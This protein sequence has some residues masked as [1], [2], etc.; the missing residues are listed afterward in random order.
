MIKIRLQSIDGKVGDPIYNEAKMEE[1]VN[2]AIKDNIDL[3]VEYSD[4]VELIW[5]G[6][7]IATFGCNC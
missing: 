3:I 4:K 2:Q 6:K 7:V 5:D 1:A